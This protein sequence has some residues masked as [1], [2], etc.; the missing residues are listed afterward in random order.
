[1]K[2]KYN[3]EYFEETAK[4][5]RLLLKNNRPLWSRWTKIIRTYKPNGKLLDVGCGVGWFLAY[6]ERY[7]DTYGLDISE[8]AINEAKQRTNAKLTIGGVSCL[9]CKDAYFDI[10]TCFD[11]LEHIRTP[12]LAI[13]EFHR[14]LKPNGLLVVRIPNTE[15]VGLKLKDKDWFGL[16][17]KT[18]ISLFDNETWIGLLDGNGFTIESVFYDGL[19]DTPYFK[20][21]PKI[22]QDVTIKYPSLVLFM[23]GFKFSQKFGEN[24]CIMAKKVSK[25]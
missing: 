20:R 21:I 4:G 16:R 6:V 11:L 24:L 25:K 5:V 2:E 10:V 9:D 18:H 23:L 17:D 1:M 22:L 8:Y 7:Y 14:I 12:W 3:K 13:E 15:S 19:W